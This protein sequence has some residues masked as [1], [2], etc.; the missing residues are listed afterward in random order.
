MVFGYENVWC[1]V[2]SYLLGFGD[3]NQR[4]LIAWGTVPIGDKNRATTN[5]IG[6]LGTPLIDIARPL[7]TLLRK[8]PRVARRAT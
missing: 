1:I 2:M 8:A 3:I 7:A 4:I 6:K 5:R